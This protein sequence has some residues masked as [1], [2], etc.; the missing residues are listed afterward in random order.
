MKQR[1]I[2]GLAVAALLFGG[3]CDAWHRLAFLALDQG[4]IADHEDFRPAGQ[5]Q[6]GIDLYAAGTIRLRSQPFRRR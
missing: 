1:A 6:I 3:G 4:C 5:R 2:L